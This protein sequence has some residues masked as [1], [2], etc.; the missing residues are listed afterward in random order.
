MFFKEGSSTD[1]LIATTKARNQQTNTFTAFKE[2]KL[3]YRTGIQNSMSMKLPFKNEEKV[4][5]LKKSLSLADLHL[6]Q[7][8]NGQDRELARWHCG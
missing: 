8:E 1:F 3:A 4:K 2:K 7:D 6:I 5:T